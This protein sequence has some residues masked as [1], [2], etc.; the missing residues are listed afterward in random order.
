MS[1]SPPYFSHLLRCSYWLFTDM[2]NYKNYKKQG[3]STIID[4]LLPNEL[5]IST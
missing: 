1:N 5:K 3:N 2:R 4:E